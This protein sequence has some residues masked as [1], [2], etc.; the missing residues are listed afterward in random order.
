MLSPCL[1]GKSLLS[2]DL[3]GVK[4]SVVKILFQTLLLTCNFPFFIFQS[5]W[6]ENSY[7]DKTFKHCFG[8]SGP[9]FAT[10]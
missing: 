9:D 7:K 6:H 3:V 10:Y 8:L 4:I 2:L 1:D 5:V